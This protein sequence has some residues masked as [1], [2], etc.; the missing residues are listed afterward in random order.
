MH[1]F[2]IQLAVFATSTV[3]MLVLNLGSIGVAGA[4]PMMGSSVTSHRKVIGQQS[5]K[6]ATVS[7]PTSAPA[8]IILCDI[9]DYSGQSGQYFLLQSAV[10]CPVPA[11]IQQTDYV[12]YCS[13]WNSAQDTCTGGWVRQPGPISCT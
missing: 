13:Y 7:A 3:L 12:D 6:A 11:T 9:Y 1:H 4:A 5:H 2:R 10:D 8:V